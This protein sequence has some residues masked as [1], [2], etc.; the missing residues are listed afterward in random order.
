MSGLTELM[1]QVVRDDELRVEL[2]ANPESVFDEY[3]LNDAERE[4]VRRGDDERISSLVDANADD[5]IGYTGDS[6]DNIGYTGDSDDNI[7]Y[8]GDSDDNI[9]YTGDSDDNIGYTGDSD[10]NIG[11]TGD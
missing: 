9:G 6:D 5:N 8:T 11:Y 1:R 3:E 10:D 4:A 7:G 2:E